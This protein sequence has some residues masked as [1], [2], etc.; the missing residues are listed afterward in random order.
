MAEQSFTH[1][2]IM[3]ILSGMLAGMFLAA[4]DQTIVATA[5]PRILEDLGGIEQLSW[6]VTAYLLTATASTPLFGKIS[7]LYG[8]RLLFQIALGSFLVGSLLCGL[9]QSMLQLVL[10]RGVQGIGGGGLM[11]ISFTILGDVL[12][13]R[14]R[15]K[16]MGYFS[17]TFA[18]AGVA[19]PV[20]GGFLVDAIDWRW[21]F[22][23]NL[24]IGA[25]AFVVVSRNLRLD[26]P[27]RDHRIDYLGATLLVASV[28]ALLVVTS[29]SGPER[30]WASPTSLG[31]GALGLALAAVFVVWERRA[32]EPMLPLHLFSNRIFTVCAAVSF[33]ISSS[34]FLATFF[35]PLFLQAVKGV[36]ATSSGLLL[37][38]VM[39]GVAISSTFAGRSTTRTGRYKRWLVLGS[40]VAAVG[41]TAMTTISMSTS[42]LIVGVTMFVIG[43]GLGM[44]FPMLNL[45]TQNSVQFADLGV[46]T[47]AIRFAQSLGGS[48]AVAGA[49][50]LLATRLQAG[51]DR[52]ADDGIA[53][54]DA[55]SLDASSVAN[56]PEQILAL[57]EPLR[58]GVQNALADAVGDIFLAGLPCVVLAFLATWF[59]REL[60]LRDRRLVTDTEPDTVTPTTAPG[61][62][63][64]AL[65][66]AD[67]AGDAAGNGAPGAPEQGTSSGRSG[68]DEGAAGPTTAPT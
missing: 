62:P 57:D 3:R 60:P 41:I 26:L 56:G 19:G 32:P 34:M 58:T 21:I 67:A 5:L 54:A 16:Y 13:P 38:P 28:T 4:M 44:V 66:G 23:V 27:V 47:S 63:A 7:D 31:L 15:G 43:V 22:L 42:G 35:L 14:Q 17:G 68:A 65:D 55:G 25:V 30:G 11:A 20:I 59:I 52:L 24:P 9:A 64:T 12:T 33:L 40:G 53:G 51:L 36:S 8:R 10:A 2:E 49:G 18:F 46:A 1:R 29:W 39:A 45:A 37:A 50:A 48:F 61:A 6:V